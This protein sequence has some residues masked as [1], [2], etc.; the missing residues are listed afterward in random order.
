M[1]ALPSAADAINTGGG[2]KLAAVLTTEST[3]VD[4]TAVE[5]DEE[6]EEEDAVKVVAGGK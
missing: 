3:G 6:E 4:A 5:E 2:C 1:D